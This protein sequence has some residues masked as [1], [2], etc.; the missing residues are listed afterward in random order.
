MCS[1]FESK[2]VDSSGASSDPPGAGASATDGDH[3]GRDGTAGQGNGELTAAGAAARM[4][5]VERHANSA[6][7]MDVEASDM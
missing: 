4:E 7:V 3:V 2:E 1:G 5:W 6:G